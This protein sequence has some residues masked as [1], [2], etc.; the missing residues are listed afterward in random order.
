[1]NES[2][3]VS[4]SVSVARAVLQTAVVSLGTAEFDHANAVHAQRAGVVASLSHPNAAALNDL[5]RLVNDAARR[6]SVCKMTVDA[7]KD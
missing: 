3:P 4:V 6:V 2:T 5:T 1:M 7:A